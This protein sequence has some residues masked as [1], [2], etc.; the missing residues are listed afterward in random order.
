MTAK[1]TCIK[2]DNKFSF[3]LL[4]NY[5]SEHIKS[6]VVKVELN[7]APKHQAAGQETPVLVLIGNG[8]LK[9]G[10]EYILNTVPIIDL[11]RVVHKMH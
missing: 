3:R 9:F 2:N 5:V 8:R 7:P 6:K 11:S 1:N 10:E 4:F